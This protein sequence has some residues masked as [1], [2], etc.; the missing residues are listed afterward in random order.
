MVILI[1]F[2]IFIFIYFACVCVC[3]CF[4]CVFVCV[5][6]TDFKCLQWPEE[7]G[8]FNVA[9]G[10]CNTDAGDQTHFLEELQVP[11]NVQSK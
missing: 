4:V 11:L 3:V 7:G 1:S 10:V 6:A 8:A 9:I 5:C 2:K